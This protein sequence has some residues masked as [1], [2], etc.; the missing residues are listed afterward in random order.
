MSAV[1]KNVVSVV[2]KGEQAYVVCLFVKNAEEVEIQAGDILAIV[3]TALTDKGVQVRT[4]GSV[5]S[6]DEDALAEG[7]NKVIVEATLTFGA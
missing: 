3:K 6:F 7:D 1:K 2:E 5:F 4:N